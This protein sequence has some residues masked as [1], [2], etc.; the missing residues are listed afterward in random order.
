MIVIPAIDIR[1]GRCVRLEQGQM[2]KETVYSKIP[3]EMAR[4]WHDHGAERLHLVDLDGATQ[5]KP[6]NR[7]SI[8]NIIR[9]VPIPVQLGGGIRDMKTIEAYL[10]LGIHQVILG[11]AAIKDPS[12]L[13][14]ACKAFP[15]RIILGIDAR[16]NQVAVEGWTE[17]TGLTPVEMAQRVESLGVAAI[18]YT[19]IHRD[20][21]QTGPNIEA[22]GELAKA[23]NVPVIAS[24]GISNIEDIKKV[25]TLVESGVTGMI[26]GRAL[27]EGTLDLAAAIRLTKSQ[28]SRFR[29]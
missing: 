29:S 16:D 19:D 14:S 4:K 13:S 2:S 26:T 23:V 8:G 27:Y 22:T 25:L 5:G 24:G 15:D 3:E 12:L 17:G 7:E 11:T 18:I 9:S 28:L 1:D 20:G 6:M 21:M 10:E